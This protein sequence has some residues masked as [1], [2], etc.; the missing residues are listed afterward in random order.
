MT[1]KN[2][3]RAVLA[4][5]AA[6]GFFTDRLRWIIPSLRCGALA[7]EQFFFACETPAI[8]CQIA[9]FTNNPMARNHDRHGIGRASTGHRANGLGPSERAGYLRVRSRGSARDALQLLPDAAL[10]G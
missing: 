7:C 2:A 6:F 3:A 8:A 9:V 10:K 5:R 4:L 1:R